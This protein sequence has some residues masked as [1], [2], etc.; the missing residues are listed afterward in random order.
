MGKKTTAFSATVSTPPADNSNPVSK[1]DFCRYLKQQS[2]YFFIPCREIWPA[3]SVNA[4]LPRI[5]VLNKNGQ[6][7]KAK[8]GKFVTLPATHWIDENQCIEQATWHPGLPLFIA[9][10]L[11]VAGG[12]VHKRSTRSFNL[13][14]PP[15]IVPGDDTRAT[16]W[17]DHVRKIYPDEA[18]HIIQWLAYHRQHPGD[19]VNHALVLSGEQ[20]IG[21]DSILAPVKHAI[22][23]WNFQEISPETLFAPFNEFA[24]SIILRINEGHDL[25]E[26]NRFKFYDRIKIY[27]ANPPEV[28]RVNE[29][30]IKEYYALN[31][32][33]VIIT[34]NHKTTGL[35]LPADDRR[36]FVAWSAYQVKDFADTYWRELWD[37]FAA[38]GNEHVTAYLD[39]LDLSDFNPKAPPPKTP[40]FWQIVNVN[41]APEDADM[42]DALEAIAQKDAIT[43]SDLIEKADAEFAEWLLDRRNRRA[44]P[45]RLDRCGYVALRNRDAKDG[46]WKVNDRRQ[47]IY[48]RSEL[49]PRRQLE[50]AQERLKRG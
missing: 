48:V 3:T 12:W 21:K 2:A 24:K 46:Y 35:Y 34:T 44:I 28:L 33:G 42:M 39:T 10:R 45:H 16:P 38:G 43:I 17:V 20:G 7:R 41:A 32:L 22:G 23:P 27:T 47:P 15:N 4:R 9:D 1:E 13:Y 11:A 19:K 26:V 37:Y 40:V 18:D 25:G 8:N 50:A 36:H 5:P 31:C 6:P 30:H 14:R 49:E 29:K